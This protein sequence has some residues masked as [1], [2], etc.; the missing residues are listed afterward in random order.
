MHTLHC[1]V[2]FTFID[3]RLSVTWMLIYS[4]AMYNSIVMCFSELQIRAS[5]FQIRWH[6]FL[7]MWIVTL[8]SI[9]LKTRDS[10]LVLYKADF[11]L[12]LHHQDLVLNIHLICHWTLNSH[13][14]IYYLY[15]IS[16]VPA[17]YVEPRQYTATVGDASFQIQCLV[18]ATPGATSW[19]WTF[20]PVGGSQQTIAQ[21]TNDNQ[22]TVDNSGTNPYLTIKSI[23]LNEAGIYTCYATNSAGT[24]D[25][26]N[27]PSS[28]HTLTVT[29][30]LFLNT[31]H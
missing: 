3:H 25:G 19:Y 18:T 28:R 13:Q 15:Y 8:W 27:N 2:F 24:S 17:T 10:V 23:A 6:V 26:A 21:G 9:K 20:Q 12:I 5:W 4:Y 31:A 14:F 30:G 1:D 29:G 22:Y 7:S 16:A 11:L